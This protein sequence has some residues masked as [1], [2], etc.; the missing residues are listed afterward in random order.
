[1]R[2]FIPSESLEEQQCPLQ[3]LTLPGVF[4]DSFVLA[5]RY[6]QVDLIHGL[7]SKL[8][9]DIGFVTLAQGLLTFAPNE[10]GAGD[11]T[12]HRGEYQRHA[13]RNDRLVPFRT[14][15]EPLGKRWLSG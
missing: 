13:G 9:L 2:T 4:G 6:L 7:K 15:A 1:I 8:A 12:E 14:P 11:E 5:F 3:Y 10:D